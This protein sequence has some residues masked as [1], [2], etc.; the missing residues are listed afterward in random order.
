MK[1]SLGSDHRGVQIKA[2]LIQTLEA[3]GFQTIDEG[4]NSSDSIDY[5]DIAAAV[6]WWPFV[7]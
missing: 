6:A 4:T 7:A 3:Q 1:V 2:R 5:P